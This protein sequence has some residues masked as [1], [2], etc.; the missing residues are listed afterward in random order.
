MADYQ[1]SV[2]LAAQADAVEVPY[3][4]Y[5]LPGVGHGFDLANTEQTQ[6]GFDVSVDFAV[7]QLTDGTPIYGRFDIPQ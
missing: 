5:S 7:A 1:S 2:D 3:A 6:V 4:F